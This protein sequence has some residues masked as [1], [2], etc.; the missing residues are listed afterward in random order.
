MSKKYKLPKQ[1]FWDYV[2]DPLGSLNN[3][4]VFYRGKDF[5]YAENMI[6]VISFAQ[7]LKYRT[8]EFFGSVFGLLFDIGEV[9]IPWTGKAVIW[10]FKA[11]LTFAAVTMAGY[12][13]WETANN[14]S[15]ISLYFDLR[16]WESKLVYA[17]AL[18]ILSVFVSVVQVEV[19]NLRN[20][21]LNLLPIN[22]LL[23]TLVSIMVGFG[24]Y[25]TA[26]Y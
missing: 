23:L 7:D 22:T 13:L 2:R 26:P 24:L 15:A 9:V 5:K 3:Y 8:N 18:V 21:F 19:W 4:F 17:G 16:W 10:F 25:L 14:M 12:L 20:T 1:T 11:T 6:Q